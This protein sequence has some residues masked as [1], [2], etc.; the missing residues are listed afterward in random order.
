MR[1]MLSFVA[2][3]CAA[4][5]CSTALAGP[6]DEHKILA[7]EEMKWG[8]GPKALPPGAEAVVLYGDPSKEGLFAMRIK[9]PKGY[10]IPP[11]THSQPE[12]VTVISGEAGLGMGDTADET[13]TRK[14]GPGS[15]MAMPPGTTHFVYVDQEAV[16]QLNSVGPWEVKYVNPKD[17]PRQKTQ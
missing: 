6:T 17:D 4:N 11:H 2:V 1:I 16:V 15:F 12:I 14:M 5:I 8:A 10:H 9:V 7:P 13:K 3:L